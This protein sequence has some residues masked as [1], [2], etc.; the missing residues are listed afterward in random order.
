MAQWQRRRRTRNTA[1][2]LDLMA[3]LKSTVTHFNGALGA[4]VHRVPARPKGQRPA[5]RRQTL[6]EQPH[7]LARR[8]GLWSAS[9]ARS[10]WPPSSTSLPWASRSNSS[11]RP[12]RQPARSRAVLRAGS[13]PGTGRIGLRQLPSSTCC[14]RKATTDPQQAKRLFLAAVRALQSG[15]QPW[16]H[17]NWRN[18]KWVL[19]DDPEILFS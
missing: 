18:V 12:S 15:N 7:V 10:P 3:S 17:W 4:D 14:W 16:P 2:A 9:G 5:R 13:T 11:L 6:R 8:I 19:A 1:A